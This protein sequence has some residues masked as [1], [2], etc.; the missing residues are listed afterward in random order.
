VST[1]EP[2]GF[3]HGQAV[4]REYWCAALAVVPDLS[5]S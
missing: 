1:P 5:R 4:L 3:A 2:D